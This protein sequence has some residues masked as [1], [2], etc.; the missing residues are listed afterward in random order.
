MRD[1]LQDQR[2]RAVGFLFFV[3]GIVFAS[4]ATN[5]PFI[6][7]NYGLTEFQIGA[8]LLAMATGAIVFMLLTGWLTRIIGSR[9]MSMISTLMFPAAMVWVFGASDFTHFMVGVILLGAANGSMDVA[10]NQQAASH[11]KA[12]AR[13]IMSSLHGCFSI[14]ALVG[15]L[16]T[17]G[18]IALGGTP[19]QQSF[20]VL[21]LVGALAI[22]LFPNLIPGEQR[23]LARDH[24][25]APSGLR[26]K[27]LWIFGSLSFLTM[28]SEGAV[29]DWS[30]IYLIEYTGVD[31][32]T[33][34]LGFGAYA[35]L[36]IVARFSG[37]GLSNTLGHRAIIIL[38]GSLTMFGIIVVLGTPLLYLQF[39]GFGLLGMGLANLIPVIFSNS[40]K[41]GTVHPGTGI[42]FVSVCGYSGFLLGPAAIGGLS[43]LIGL[44]GALLIVVAAGL[45]A[46]LAASAFPSKTSAAPA[47]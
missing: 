27:K 26:N 36:T 4:W 10:M 17:F 8:V 5:I 23:S 32:D 34:A 29:A 45:V 46:I 25:L 31:A 44:D 30:A 18:T 6:Q 41:L 38:S 7:S 37:D 13:P 42:A 9:A 14:G 20:L 40:A 28:L 3:N 47:E 12:R 33:A 43:P 1:L 2:T 21:C 22:A 15:S 19:V 24:R 35:L 16:L 11:E 39:L